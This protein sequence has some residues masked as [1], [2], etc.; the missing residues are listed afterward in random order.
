M[1]TNKGLKKFL[2]ISKL[3]EAL[4]VLAGRDLAIKKIISMIN[5]NPTVSSSMLDLGCGPGSL[6]SFIPKNVDYSGIDLEPNYVNAAKVSYPESKF[7]LG[8]IQELQDVIPSGSQFDYITAIGLFHHVND[9]IAGACFQAIKNFI[10]PGSYIIFF[11]PCFVDKQGFISKKLM[12]MDRGQCIRHYSD[13]IKLVAT[14]FPHVD[15][16]LCRFYR[17]PYFHIALTIKI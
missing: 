2:Q 17:I 16:S 7:Y 14:Y 1:Q 12:A 3:Y 9:D 11:E 4:Q 13:W 10:K 15:H 5:F 6:R 8:G